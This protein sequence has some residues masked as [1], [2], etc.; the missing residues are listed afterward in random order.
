MTN[1]EVRSSCFLGSLAVALASASVWALVISSL[2][3]TWLIFA[4]SLVAALFVWRQ[5]NV[6]LIPGNEISADKIRTWQIFVCACIALYF[7][8]M[9]AVGVLLLKNGVTVPMKITS[10]SLLLGLYVLVAAVTLAIRSR[11]E[12]LG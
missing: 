4:V 7:F 11:T 12:G 5:K 2:V 1:G 8:A 10:T 9:V 3:A 6:G